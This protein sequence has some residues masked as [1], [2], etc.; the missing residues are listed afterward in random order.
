M[1]RSDGRELR[2]AGTGRRRALVV[3]DTNRRQ[4]FISSRLRNNRGFVLPPTPAGQ[5]GRV[6]LDPFP[7]AGTADRRS[8]C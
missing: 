4:A 2:A 5:P 7:S 6:I 8:R 1:R 3:S